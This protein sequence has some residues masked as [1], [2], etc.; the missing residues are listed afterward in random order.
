MAFTIADALEDIP[1]I[2]VLVQQIQAGVSA[3]PKPSKASDYTK[4]AAAVLPA[5]GAMIDTVEAQI[6]AGAPPVPAAP[7]K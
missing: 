5:V 7:A 6:K 3:L 4:L 2:L 1:E